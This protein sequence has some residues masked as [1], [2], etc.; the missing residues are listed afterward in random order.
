MSAAVAVLRPDVAAL[1]Q[2]Y[3]LFVTTAHH[4]KV[5]P[6]PHHPT[7]HKYETGQHMLGKG[8]QTQK[9]LATQCGEAAADG[10]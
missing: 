9:Q 5:S 6:R 7:C 8:V 2:R 4:S 1:L 10:K 3:I